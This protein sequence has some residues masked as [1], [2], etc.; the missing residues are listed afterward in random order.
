MCAKHLRTVRCGCLV[1]MPPRSVRPQTGRQRLHHGQETVFRRCEQAIRTWWA[2]VVQ[3]AVNAGI[4]DPRS[5]RGE[6]AR[7]GRSPSGGRASARCWPHC[8]CGAGRVVPT[9]QLVD[10]LY[11]AEPP[12][13]ATA[14]LHNSVVALRKALGPDVLVTRPP[15]Y[16]LAVSPTRSTRGGSSSCWRTRGALPGRAP[17]AAPPRARALARPTARR[18][19]VRRLGAGRDPPARRAAPRRERGADR[20]GR[21]ARP[22]GR[23][24]PRARDPR[25]R[26]SAA[27]TAVRAADARALSRPVA[28][29]TR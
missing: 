20:R 13:T 14:S 10:E 1:V 4:S 29:R 8:S 19:R 7:T 26:G 3:D 12:K 2:P 5:A 21:R 23:R 25:R 27:R 9:E 6:R 15:G 28:R 16:V 18:V 22:P 17:L 24:R 11:G